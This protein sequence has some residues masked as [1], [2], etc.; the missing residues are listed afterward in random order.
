MSTL[1]AR[2]GIRQ[3]KE[4]EKNIAHRKEMAEF[5]DSLLEKKGWVSRK[6][7]KSIM[8]PVMVRYPVRIK[9]KEEALEQAAK[10]GIELGSWFNSV[11]HQ[12][13]VVA[14]ARWPWNGYDEVC[15]VTCLGA[16]A[17]ITFVY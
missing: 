16:V 5:Y 2:V 9:E 4:I 12:I 3:L 8:E 11:L 6:Y 17:Q 15:R 13:E 7:D 10:V 1:Q 14:T